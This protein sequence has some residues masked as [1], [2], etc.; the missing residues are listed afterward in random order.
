MASQRYARPPSQDLNHLLHVSC[1]I[2]DFHAIQIITNTDRAV[3]HFQA[4]SK[5]F[6]QTCH[7]L[8]AHVELGLK[9]FSKLEHPILR[10]YDCEVV[11]VT[12]FTKVHIGKD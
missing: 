12:R 6:T 10:S 1:V 2:F 7:A 9:Q 8:H 4:L 3:K 5:P 11:P